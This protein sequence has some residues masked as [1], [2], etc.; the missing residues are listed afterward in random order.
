MVEN[1]YGNGEYVRNRPHT[2]ELSDLKC[3]KAAPKEKPYYL[4]DK[5]GLYLMV[6]PTGGRLW[7]WR[8]R[9]GGKEKQMA[10]GKY[11]DVPLADARLHHAQARQ[12]LA[13]GVDPMAIRK[14]A[15]DQ[16]KAEQ[17]EV[18]K[19]VVKKPVG[20]TFEKLAEKWFEWW[21]A[22][23]DTKHVKNVQARLKGDIIKPLG[24]KGPEEITRMD[25]VKLIQDTD[26]RGAHD[27]AKRNLHFVRQIYEYGID[28]WLL[29]KNTIN[30]AAGIKPKSILTK[31]VEE[32]FASIPI[33]EVPELLRKVQ[34]YDGSA[35]TRY[36]MDMLSLTFLRTGELIG[37][38]WPEI[39]WQGK[40]WRIPKERMKIKTRPH[41]VPLSNQAIAL[42]ERLYANTG[43]TGRLFPCATG[44]TG[45]MSNNTILKA[46][47]R[48]GY[49]HRM[50]GHGWRSIAS[51]YLH[52]KGFDHEHIELQ[53]AH[54]KGDKVSGAYS[55]AKYLEPRA[56]MMQA[57]ADTLDQLREK[58]KGGAVNAI[59]LR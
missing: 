42:L 22:G 4:A 9:F 37:G 14:G 39:D 38:L 15:K 55:Y 31:V 7:R 1:M 21:K 53:L 6:V 54:S 28:N 44:D 20:L 41:I 8:Y 23:K 17:A 43:K 5:G 25:V 18:E 35:L 32:H 26:A 46:L 50:T 34:D 47:E 27:I 51:T 3:R 2:A 52:E 48:M 12:F 56:M 29:D 40:A 36:A 59:K 57:W 30:P 33:A 49:K 24:S 16:K 45:S 10:F 13:N 58:G 11:P 19:A